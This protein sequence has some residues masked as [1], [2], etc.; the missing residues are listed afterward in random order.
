MSWTSGKQF[1]WTWIKM[2]GKVHEYSSASRRHL[3]K[4]LYS[5]P[6][7]PEA[8]A[9]STPMMAYTLEEHAMPRC[10]SFSRCCRRCAQISACLSSELLIDKPRRVGSRATRTL[11]L[12][13]IAIFQAKGKVILETTKSLANCLDNLHRKPM[14]C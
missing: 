2:G 12:V 6:A 11:T 3:S 14:R 9:C 4:G 7:R 1:H 5:R 10:W 13:L 8:S